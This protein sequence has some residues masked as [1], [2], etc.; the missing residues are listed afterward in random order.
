MVEWTE[1][2][3]VDPLERNLEAM[4]VGSM[5]DWR[6]YHLG[7]YLVAWKEWNSVEKMEMRKVRLWAGL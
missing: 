2:M 3:L 5:G 6:E 1:W 7:D 4:K